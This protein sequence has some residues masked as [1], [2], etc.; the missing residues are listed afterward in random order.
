MMTRVTWFVLGAA[1]ASAIWIV[2]FAGLGH[3]ILDV[4]FGLSGGR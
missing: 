1:A 4:F 2:V 3:R